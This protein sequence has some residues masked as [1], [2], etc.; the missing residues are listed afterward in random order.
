MFGYLKGLFLYKWGDQSEGIQR[1][2]PILGA[3]YIQM[4]AKIGENFSTGLLL[5]F[6]RFLSLCRFLE[7]G[8]YWWNIIQGSP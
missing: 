7:E 5:S 4:Q 8:F 2:I 3:K 1:K 6:G